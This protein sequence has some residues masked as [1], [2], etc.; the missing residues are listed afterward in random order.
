MSRLGS[1]KATLLATPRHNRSVGGKTTLQNL[2]PADNLAATRIEILLHAV[3]HVALQLIDTL[4]ALLA[5]AALA[6]LT[7]LPVAL[8]SLVATDVDI[9]RGE[10]LNNLVE[11]RLHHLEG[12][13]LAD[14]EVAL[15][16]WSVRTLQLGIC[17]QDLVG[18][19]RHLYLGDD[20]YVAV[21]SIGHQ[22]AS[23]LLCEV[24][25]RS[26]LRAL[27]Y[28]LPIAIPPTLPVVGRAPCGVA[29]KAW[30]A[31][32]LEAP[33]RSIREVQVQAVH[34]HA[35]HHIY[36]T[37]K[38]IHRAEVARNIYKRTA[39]LKARIVH[40]MSRLPLATLYQLTNGLY[41]IEQAC[42]IVTPN[43]HILFFG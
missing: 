22:L 15:T 28:K 34:L 2:I 23:L 35:R 12:R 4:Q 8:A 13:L 19:A 40:Y 7:Q 14:A 36:L 38:E 24:A 17:R 3:Y 5:H 18:V 6:I 1:H 10:Y 26:T 21:G 11:Y 32:N 41:G 43:N 29:R 9:L 39:V 33:A 25:A 31:L 37:L 42:G 16:L 30:V 20:G 27:L